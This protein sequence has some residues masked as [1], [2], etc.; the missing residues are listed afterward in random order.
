MYGM[1]LDE[2]RYHVE[3]S[4]RSL[5]QDV[6]A[7]CANQKAALRKC[8]WLLLWLG[9]HLITMGQ[10]VDRIADFSESA[11]DGMIGTRIDPVIDG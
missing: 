2:I 4:R 5:T 7:S 3:E 11:S 6:Q 10:R 1:N 9:A 8:S